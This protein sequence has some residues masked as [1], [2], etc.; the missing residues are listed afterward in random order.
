M[1]ILQILGHF[2][3]TTFILIIAVLILVS[4]SMKILKEYERGVL[5]R[6]GRYKGLKGPGL[7]LIIPFVDK[8]TK[9]NLRLLVMDVPRQEMITRDNVP[10]TIDAVIYFRITDPTNA[11]IEIDDVVTATTLIA[12]TTL[13]SVIGQVELD[14]VLSQ[15]EKINMKLR[16]LILEQTHKWGVEVVLIETK[17][18]LLPESM[19]RA[20]A[21]QAEVE[22]ERRAKIVAADAE[23]Q[24]AQKLHDAAMIMGQSPITFQLRYLQLLAEI[25]AKSPSTIVIPPPIDFI[26]SFYKNNSNDLK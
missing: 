7:V 18:V 8:I 10:V 11:V 4:S 14:E 13:R 24:T 19:R 16:A 20:M 22:R 17:E 23:F 1:Q 6:L 25:T 3:L 15:R 2:N 5:F 9:I 21:R 26:K 12:Q